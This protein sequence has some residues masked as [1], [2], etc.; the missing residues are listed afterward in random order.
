LTH[1]AQV[2]SKIFTIVLSTSVG[3]YGYQQQA[4]SYLH[5]L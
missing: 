2:V 5:S 1:S 3:V 4:C